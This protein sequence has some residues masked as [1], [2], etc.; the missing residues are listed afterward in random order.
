M[1]VVKITPVSIIPIITIERIK[2]E[3]EPISKQISL[4]QQPQ[5]SLNL[6]VQLLRLHHHRSSLR[7]RLHG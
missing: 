2:N 7:T 5:N 6:A 1:V 3:H 4:W